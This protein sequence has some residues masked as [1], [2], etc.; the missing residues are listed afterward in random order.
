MDNIIIWLT[1]C[2]FSIIWGLFHY[3]A[4]YYADI[5]KH[6]KYFKFLEFWRLCINYFVTLVI[7]YY[8]VTVRWAHIG[9]GS[10]FSTGD[11]ILGI[12]FIIGIFGWLPYFVKNITEGISV[13]FKKY[14]E[15]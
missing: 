6:N 14:F 2:I 10:N 11:F 3:N 12:I 7:A 1:L 5:D 13:I 9:Q 4:G 15:K 8:F